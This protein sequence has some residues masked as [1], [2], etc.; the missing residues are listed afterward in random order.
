MK[1]YHRLYGLWEVLSDLQLL[2]HRPPAFKIDHRPQ[3]QLPVSELTNRVKH[4]GLQNAP[5][6]KHNNPRLGP[7][8]GM[9]HMEESRSEPE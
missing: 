9:T 4:S 3:Y 2:V 1:I 6:T 5:V 8:A 7:V